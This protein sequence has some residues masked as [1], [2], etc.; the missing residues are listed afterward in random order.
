MRS[1]GTERRSLGIRQV[2]QIRNV[3]IRF[4]DQV[5]ERGQTVGAR[6][7]VIDPEPVVAPDEL[8]LHRSLAAV[9][10]TDRAVAAL[11]GIRPHRLMIGR[12]SNASSVN[13]CKTVEQYWANGPA[14]LTQF[15]SCWNSSAWPKSLV[16]PG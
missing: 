3:P 2:G 11:G 4:D 16:V 10:R 5:A 9:L 8:A 7:A 14:G 15:F 13:Q 1:Q 12:P 6:L